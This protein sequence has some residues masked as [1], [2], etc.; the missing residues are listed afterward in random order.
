MA[1]KKSVK[2]KKPVKTK[3][4]DPWDVLKHPYLT[5][6]SMSLVERANTIVFSVDRK[7]TKTEIKQAFE[8]IFEVK[9]DS[10]NTMI[11]PTGEKR[12]FIKLKRGYNASDVAV[13]LG[14]V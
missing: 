8:Q 2:I 4:K 10:V 12:A 9:V 14:A 5:E 6:K 7:S 13:K 11:S 3:I 1:K